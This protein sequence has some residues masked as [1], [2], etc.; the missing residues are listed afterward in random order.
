[1]SPPV[2]VGDLRLRGNS[3]GTVNN[4]AITLIAGVAGS[5]LLG[6]V[7]SILKEK[8]GKGSTSICKDRIGRPGCWALALIITSYAL[9]IPGLFTC[10]FSI[11]IGAM[12]RMSLKEGTEST[13]SFIRELFSTGGVL[14]GIFVLAFATVIP[15]I[16]IM[17]FG[18]GELWRDSP[19]ANRVRVARQSIQFLQSASK[20]A[21]PDMFAYIFLLYLVRHLNKPPLLNGLMQLDTGFT[22]FSLFCLGSTIAALGIS[23]PDSPCEEG[24]QA[25]QP[26]SVT[27]QLVVCMGD[28][29]V[30][31]MASCLTIISVT[32]LVL[33]LTTPIMALS[34]D[35]DVLYDNGTIPSQL[36]GVVDTF[37]LPGLARADVSIWLCI[38]KLAEWIGEG[39]VNSVI[40]LVMV[41]VGV[42]AC[43]VLD[44]MVLN[45]V[46]FGLSGSRPV[47]ASHDPSS[48]L[49]VIH[50]L[51]KLSMLDVLIVGVVVTVLSASTYHSQGLVLDLRPGLLILLGAEICHQTLYHVVTSAAKM[52]ASAPALEASEQEM[53]AT[54]DGEP[55]DAEN[56]SSSTSESCSNSWQVCE[57]VLASA[58]AC[59]R[60][61]QVCRRSTKESQ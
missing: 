29:G 24:E 59:C 44:I 54:A 2:A 21:C 48:S 49:A 3:P 40:A 13:A 41:A 8:A 18:L 17:L 32:L 50:V 38:R 19:S 20:W 26:P 9:L 27:R 12:G 23:L 46:A 30:A 52:A 22:C 39:E 58:F 11:N 25:G 47:E 42:V 5:A 33:G 34:L 43:T 60:I 55:A 31:T 28:R 10:L 51:K 14:G 61:V 36:K 37:D 57:R 35:V 1:M 53:E 56:N 15:G 7:H 16:K 4:V 45:F 6:R